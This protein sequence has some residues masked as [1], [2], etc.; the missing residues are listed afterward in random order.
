MYYLHC[1]HGPDILWK[2]CYR[3]ET[4]KFWDL[5]EIVKFGPDCGTLSKFRNVAGLV[6]FCASKSC[7]ISQYML[8]GQGMYRAAMTA[9]NA[10]LV[11]KL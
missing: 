9:K 8:G 4:V 10:R 7:T 3:V 2:F 11:V 5:A 6:C 1:L